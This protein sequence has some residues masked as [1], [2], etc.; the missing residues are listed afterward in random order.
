MQLTLQLTRRGLIR[1]LGC[2]VNLVCFY[3]TLRDATTDW[4][5]RH[6][7]KLYK[8]EINRLEEL[9]HEMFCILCEFLYAMNVMT[10]WQTHRY[11]PA[12]WTP[13]GAYD[14][15]NLHDALDRPRPNDDDEPDS[16]PLTSVFIYAA[17]YVLALHHEG[18]ERRWWELWDKVMPDPKK[19]YWER[20]PDDFVVKTIEIT[21]RRRTKERGEDV[22]QG[23]D[24]DWVEVPRCEE[25][26]WLEVSSRESFEDTD[27]WKYPSPSAVRVPIPQSFGG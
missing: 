21:F 2:V 26:D 3:K 23:E 24:G 16:L 20:Y 27:S 9:R 14:L 13:S 12:D 11:L 8:G 4:D 25:E 18:I 10:I 17:R 19:E 22:A 15:H 6:E 7:P 5:A 1:A